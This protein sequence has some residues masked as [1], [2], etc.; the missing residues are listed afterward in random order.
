MRERTWQKNRSREQGRNRAEETAENEAENKAENNASKGMGLSITPPGQ[1][2]HHKTA[3]E[4][5]MISRT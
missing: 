3:P 2:A 1:K 5:C 4:E